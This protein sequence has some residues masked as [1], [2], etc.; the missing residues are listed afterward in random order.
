MCTQLVL[1]SE[2]C[3]ATVDEQ[4][5]L[6]GIRGAEAECVSFSTSSEDGGTPNSIAD[7]GLE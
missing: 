2:S 1:P 7:S 5:L 6:A 4:T 3:A